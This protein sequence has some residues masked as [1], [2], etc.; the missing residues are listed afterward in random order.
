[1]KHPY[2]TMLD[3]VARNPYKKTRTESLQYAYFCTTF[4]RNAALQNQVQE[5]AQKIKHSA[6]YT[7]QVIRYANTRYL[8]TEMLSVVLLFYASQ[9]ESGEKTLPEYYKLH[10][11]AIVRE[12]HARRLI[13]ESK[14]NARKIKDP[15]S[16]EAEKR[17][18][19]AL[20]NNT[21]L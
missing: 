7:N 13:V 9:I 18:L 3:V 4:K 20:K 15:R 14:I 2:Q 17:V 12:I 11:M 1:M 8:Q 16:Q 6:P 19:E 10:N 5:R 21:P